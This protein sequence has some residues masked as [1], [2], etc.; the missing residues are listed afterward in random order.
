MLSH[1][2]GNKLKIVKGTSTVMFIVDSNFRDNYR[3]V[4]KTSGKILAISVRMD[5]IL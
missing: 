1:L 5:I 3:K 4:L 2:W